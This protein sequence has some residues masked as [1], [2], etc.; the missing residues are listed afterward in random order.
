M[1]ND[2]TERMK[3]CPNFDGCSA[4][5]WPLDEQIDNRISYTDEPKCTA[6]KRT[7][8]KIG[9]ELPNMGL[10]KTELNGLTMK[11]G[12]LKIAKEALLQKI[13]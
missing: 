4:P 13:Q 1:G 7:R 6:T 5:K 12:T 8:F 3:K 9:H 11:Y 2:N 10:T